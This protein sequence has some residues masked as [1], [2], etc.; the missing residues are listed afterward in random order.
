MKQHNTLKQMELFKT[1]AAG[2]LERLRAIVA[3]DPDVLNCYDYRNFGATPLT[4]ACFSNRPT[5]V[6]TLIEL[7]ADP[8]KKSDWN[9]GPWSPLHCA[10]FRRDK[11]L[12][13]YLLSHGAIMDV[14]T[15]AGLGNHEAVVRLLETD[16]SRVV[17]KGGDGCHPLHFADTTEVAQVLLDRGAEID[18]RCIDH[19]S[20][21]AQYLCSIRPEVASYLFSKGATP[22]IFSAV[23]C[24]DDPMLERLL[25][26][27]PNLIHARIN[28]AFFPPGPEHDVHNILTF[29]I[30]LD[31]TPLH[32]A[33][34][35]NH[36]N[37]VSILVRHGLAPNVRGGYDHATP[38]HTAAWSNC[39]VSAAS[40]LENGADI[41]A[42]SGKLH[43]NSP[44]G[45]AIVAGSDS[46][47]ELLMA[48]GAQ[49]KSWF[50]EDARAACA[51]GFDQVS[52]ASPEQ[53]NRILA[54]LQ[55]A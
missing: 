40:L 50:L 33:A 30:G 5:L 43:N 22:D 55:L 4:M 14:H 53:R 13:E 35:G 6:E 24:G 41:D 34:K 38:L 28:Q 15:A 26:A 46:V 42:V 10:I 27:D 8:N 19:Y 32:A 48:R 2:D 39:A 20:T 16:P 36:S 11:Q 7:G 23:L 12:A 3:D 51:G 37:A 18:G 47:F 25:M 17:E 52:N 29:S 45:W 49:C 54:R 44:A 31:A 9:M 1:L 21:P